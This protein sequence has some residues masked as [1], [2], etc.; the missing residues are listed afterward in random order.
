M[1]F[2]KRAARADGVSTPKDG[3]W[4]ESPIMTE[5]CMSIVDNMA[6]SEAS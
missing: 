3:R 6:K 1:N 5:E 4:Y 2:A